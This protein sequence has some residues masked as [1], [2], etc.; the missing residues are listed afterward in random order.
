MK[1]KIN[2]Q[3]YAC[4]YAT[5]LRALLCACL[6]VCVLVRC[7]AP[8]FLRAGETL[9]FQLARPAAP[10]LPN[11][12]GQCPPEPP[13][14]PPPLV[15]PARPPTCTRAGSDAHGSRSLTASRSL[16][17]SSPETP[18]W[19]TNNKKSK[20]RV[21]SSRAGRK[22]PCE[23]ARVTE[24]TDKTPT[25]EDKRNPSPRTKDST[26][27]PTPPVNRTLLVVHVEAERRYEGSA[28]TNPTSS[29]PQYPIQVVNKGQPANTRPVSREPRHV[30]RT[31]TV[32]KRTDGRNS[33]KPRLL[34][35]T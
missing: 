28:N 34:S 16:P 7:G 20:Q 22:H 24:R 5:R 35:V 27:K 17:C 2:V 19:D 4:A 31:R 11:R 18:C 23:P 12:K 6:P 29:A 3:T 26:S 30:T 33:Y 1:D 21:E 10:H 25:P 9:T 13:R 8:L 15:P 14:V 32:A